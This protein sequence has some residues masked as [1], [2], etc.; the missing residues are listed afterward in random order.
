MAEFDY[1][2]VGIYGKDGAWLV[3]ENLLETSGTVTADGDAFEPG[4]DIVTVG[5]ETGQIEYTGYVQYSEELYTL[6]ATST[7]S[8]TQSYLFAPLDEQTLYP[9]LLSTSRV[10]ED[11]LTC[12]A[13]GTPI[14]TPGGPVAVECLTIGDAV[15]TADGRVVPV[16]WIG[17][18]TV[19]R[20]FTPP[21]R[22][23][24][25]RVRAHA[26]ADGVPHADLVLTADHALAVDGILANAGA[27][28]N[29]ASIVRVPMDALP[30]RVTYFHVETGA[31]ELILAAGA[32]AE[33]FV[34][35][36]T[37]TAF[38]NHPEYTALY[39]SAPAMAE[40]PLPRAMS[41]RQLPAHIRAR[42]FARAEALGLAQSAA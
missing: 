30:D 33:T 42:L 37:R 27:L 31:H 20:I 11:S 7:T 5:V 34:D 15:V 17:R 23:R 10:R 2:A 26:L 22:F 41:A 35:N 18:Q 40:L 12:F 24:P 13:A 3:R 38:D 16:R 19:P 14:A 8:P 4:D 32:P 25:V 28:V 39:R 21:E 6:I 36:G 1:V 29:G 9:Q